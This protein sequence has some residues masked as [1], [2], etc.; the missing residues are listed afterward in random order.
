MGLALLCLVLQLFWVTGFGAHSVC[1]EADGGHHAEWSGLDCAASCEGAPAGP[2]AAAC[3]AAAVAPGGGIALHDAPA[4]G[5]CTD[6]VMTQSGFRSHHTESAAP[7][8]LLAV[9]VGVAQP[10][11][12]PRAPWARYARPALRPGD[13]ALLPLRC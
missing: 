2:I 4:C 13:R 1:I 10:P 6:V 12:A 5:D 11:A 7:L 3:A 9:T 8:P